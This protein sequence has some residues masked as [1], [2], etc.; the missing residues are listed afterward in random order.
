MEWKYHMESF[1]NASSSN[2]DRLNEL[3]GERWEL[4]TVV[5]ITES[6]GG[7]VVYIFKRQQR[8]M[9]ESPQS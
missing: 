9:S 8:L 2:Q 3:G 6:L 5:P 7:D 1:R 4:V